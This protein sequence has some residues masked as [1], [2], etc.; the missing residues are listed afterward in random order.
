MFEDATFESYGRIRT[1]SRNWMLAT[2]AL[3]AGMLAAL[4]LF[5]L[6][7]PEA[8]E[9]AMRW[10]PVMI[11]E[12]PQR[13]LVKMNK[14]VSREPKSLETI[15][16]ALQPQLLNLS[17]IDRSSNAAPTGTGFYDPIGVGTTLPGDENGALPLGDAMPVVKPAQRAAVRLASSL[18]EGM[19]VRK[20]MPIYPPIARLMRVQGTVVLQATISTAGVI[21]DLRVVSGPV[22]LRQAAL[23][24]VETWVYRPYMLNGKP[25]EVGT[26]VNVEFKLE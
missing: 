14:A 11:P 1:R 15:E 8:L 26:T 25:V 5:P 18:V 3:N 20:T 21:E 7:H 17:R 4:V 24:A 6:L 10:T 23:D 2:F 22:L 16:R 12:N 19:L 9:R 13:V